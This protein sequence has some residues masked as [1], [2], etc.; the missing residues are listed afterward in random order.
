MPATLEVA[1]SLCS[2]EQVR[3]QDAPNLL[4]VPM[5][6]LMLDDSLHWTTQS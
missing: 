5:P 6:R 3:L 2:I 1:E 4:V